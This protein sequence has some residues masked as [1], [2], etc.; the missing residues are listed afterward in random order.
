MAFLTGDDGPRFHKDFQRRHAGRAAELAPAAQQAAGQLFVH[1]FRVLNDEMR[2]IL[3]QRD[4]AAGHVPFLPGGVE[5]RAEGLTETA[6][7]TG[8]QFV[9]QNHQRLGKT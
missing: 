3:D 1:R 5:N 2:Q 7:H 8:S 6:F 9:V 4:F